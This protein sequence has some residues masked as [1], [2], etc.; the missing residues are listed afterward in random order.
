MIKIDGSMGEGGGQVLRTSLALSLVTGEPFVAEKIR[1]GRKKPGLLRQHLT[2]VRAASAV[3]KAK[4]DGAEMGSQKLHFKPRGVHSGEY[5]FAVGTAGSAVLVLQ[6][7]LPALMTADGVSRVILEGG[8]HNPFAPPFPF[9]EHAFLPVLKRIGPDVR[10]TLERPGFYPAGGGRF[11]ADIHPA[12]S[13]RRI[14]LNERGEIQS[15][16]AIA[17]VAKLSPDVAKRELAALQRKLSLPDEALVVEVSETSRGPGNVLTLE[18][19]SESVTELFS[20]FGERGVL[21]ERV[22][23]KL[24]KPVR[25]YLA[26]GAPVGRHLADQLLLPMAMAGGG[27]FVTLPLTRHSET[28]IEVIKKFLPVEFDVDRSVRDRVHVTVRRNRGEM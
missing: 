13:L 4:A 19:E 25:E 8:T 22:A 14:T 3:G 10:L 16:K 23:S 21:A 20:A 18:V 9:L 2:A 1:A 7:I 15:Q 26:S 12:R 17:T 5:H 27:E 6:A 24:V 11:V 28:N